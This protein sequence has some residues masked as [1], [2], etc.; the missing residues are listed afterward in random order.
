MSDASQPYNLSSTYLRLRSDVTIE[1]LKG[2]ATFWPRL[3]SG[4]LGNFHNEYLITVFDSAQD[5]T[6]WEMHPMGDE[7]VCVLSGAV[8]ML[9]EQS[10]RPVAVRLEQPGEFVLITRGT[11]HT[12]NVS[13]ACRMLFVTAGE[14]TQHRSR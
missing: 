11:W 14:G 1:A 6:H 10:G 13:S 4:Q 3:M 12:A 2:D 7:L 5:W 8:V 9:L